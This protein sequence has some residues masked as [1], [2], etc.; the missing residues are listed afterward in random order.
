M[1]LSFHILYVKKERILCHEVYIII[2]EWDN[3]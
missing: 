2:I 3:K 1:L